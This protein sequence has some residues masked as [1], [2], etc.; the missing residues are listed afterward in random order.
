[1][2]YQRAIHKHIYN[3]W[4]GY[5]TRKVISE[6]CASFVLHCTVSGG[7]VKTRRISKPNMGSIFPIKKQGN[8]LVI[9]IYYV[10][11]QS[12]QNVMLSSD[13]KRTLM[14]LFLFTN[15]GFNIYAEYTQLQLTFLAL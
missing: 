7:N 15:S 10:N 2:L 5:D 13:T 8:I 3:A 9:R 12:Y 1:M 4:Q 6:V 14:H 11:Y